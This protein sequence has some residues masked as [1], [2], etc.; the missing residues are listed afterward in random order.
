MR[1]SWAYFGRK[2][3]IMSISWAYGAPKQSALQA[4]AGPTLGARTPNNQH[5]EHQL[6]PLRAQ[7]PQTTSIMSV[8]LVYFGRKQA[9]NKQHHEHQ[10]G[11]HWAQG[12][13]TLGARAPNNQ[14]HEHQLCLLW[15]QA[16]QTAGI[17][18]ISWVYF[19]RKAPKLPAS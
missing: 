7:G 9:P 15:A 12:P 19:G 11:R 14:H 6:G 16:A 10:L 2:G 1:I 3:A 5:H 13:Q 4:S 17:M 18:S 8:S